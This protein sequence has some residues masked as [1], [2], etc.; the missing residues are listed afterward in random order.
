MKK[1]AVFLLLFI[2][3]LIVYSF[4]SKPTVHTFIFQKDT[5]Q[6]RV[7]DILTDKDGR[8]GI[9]IKNLK[10][11]EAY[12]QNGHG[13]F[14]PGS[15]YKVWLMGAVFEKV[16]KG[17]IK[18]DDEIT[19]EVASINQEFD[20]GPEDAELNSGALDF[21]ISSALEQMITISHNYAAMVLT[22][23]VGRPAILDFLK[24]YGLLDSS[25]GT[26]LKTSAVDFGRLFEKLYIGE[27]VDKQ[28]SQKMLDILSRQ[29]INDR[30]PKYLPKEIK[31]AHKT[32]EIGYFENDAG[33]VFSPGGDFV[34]VVL[35]ETKN[36]QATG[37]R[38]AQLSKAIYDYINK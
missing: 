38:I 32:G 34:I 19:A 29:K 8:Y 22:K 2:G 36:P 18:E 4:F 3:S 16:K 25:L 12:T 30:I 33:L 24:N 23:T 6:N 17:E 5:L 13:S 37:E 11:G 14:E 20:I 35:S 15:L 26:P 21:S 28:Y 1:I 7:A 31:I 9:F 10:T 27:V